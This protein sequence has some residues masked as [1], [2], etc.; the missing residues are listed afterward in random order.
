MP[1]EK[2]SKWL[3]QRSL[4]KWCSDDLKP[5]EIDWIMNVEENHTT[6]LRWE[7]D[8]WHAIDP[9]PGGKQTPASGGRWS[10]N[11]GNMMMLAEL[12]WW[13]AERMTMYELYVMWKNLPIFA[14]KRRHSESQSEQAQYVRNAKELKY[15]EKG[16]YG[17]NSSGSRQRRG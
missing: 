5:H 9:A 12:V 3:Y 11:Q 14:F 17:L 7:L 15:Q 8:P 2:T 16:Y 13:A 1:K 10:I 6:L 4:E